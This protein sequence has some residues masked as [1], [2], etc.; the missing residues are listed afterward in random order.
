MIAAVAVAHDLPLYTCSA[1]DF[2][3][4]DDLTV[5]AVPHPDEVPEQ[6]T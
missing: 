3:D 2:A 1:E 6:R 4:I 5:I